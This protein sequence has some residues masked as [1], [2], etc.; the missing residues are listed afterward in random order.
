MAKST[1][2]QSPLIVHLIYRLDFGGLESL[3]VDCVNRIGP[4][5]FRHAII[6]LTDYTSFS[7]KI[8][9]PE[10]DIYALHKPP[11]LALALHLT[12]W[13]LFRKLR[14]AILH[15]YNL[16][17]IEYAAT[18]RLAG[19]PAVLHAEH[20]RDM[21]D[22]NGTNARHN[23]LRKHLALFIDRYV[24]VSKD[25]QQWLIQVV[26][27]PVHKQQL[28]INGV[29][30]DRFAPD[31]PASAGAES[32]PWSAQHVV[33]GTVGQ[34]RNIKNH[35]GL[36]RTFGLILQQYPAYRN[37]LRLTIVGDGSL[38]PDLKQQVIEAGLLELVW[39]PGAR[40]DIAQIMAG[41]AVF[42]LPSLAEGTPVALLEAMACGLPVVASQVGGI[43]EVIT[44][45]VNG[46][47]VAAGDEAALAAAI[48]HYVSNPELAAAQG[49]AARTRVVEAYSQ[50][51]MIETYIRLYSELCH[52]RNLPCAA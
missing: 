40:S 48:M 49:S 10:V 14:P 6:C 30:T 9:Q 52:E 16:A 41:F 42:T 2:P 23:L 33:I 32:S 29:D 39:L 11:G 38:L 47:L 44:D 3:L 46:T 26:G 45:G 7:E 12:L 25:L 43:P 51:H 24:T 17:T 31:R 21:A 36:I 28:I 22:M 5:Q 13:K 18:A 15:T 20:G 1:L 37:T 35:A 19:V 50:T 27:I 34:I 8:T 4:G